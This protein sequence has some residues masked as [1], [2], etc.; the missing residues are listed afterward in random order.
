MTAGPL[1]PALAP[2]ARLMAL[3]YRAAIARV[4]RRYDRRVGVIELDRPVISVGNLSVG[5]TGK[6][7]AVMRLLAAL[8]DAGHR[9]CV[10]MRGYAPGASAGA[11]SDEAQEY[12]RAFPDLPIAARPDRIAALLELFATPQG[13]SVDCIVLDDGFQHRRLARVLDLVLVDAT[14]SPFR[15]RLLPAGWLREPVE[16]LA[17]ARAIVV[18][19]TES[20][21]GAATSELEAALRRA[22]PRALIVLARHEWAGLRVLG[23]DGVTRAE[24]VEWLRGRR[25]FAACAIGN[26]APFLAELDRRTGLS[27]AGELVLRDHDPYAPATIGRLLDAARA[28]GPGGAVVVTSKDWSKL[29]RVRPDAWPAEVVVPTLEMRWSDPTIEAT[30]VAAVRAYRP[31]AD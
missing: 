29:R 30:V 9:P 7:P 14:R 15:D 25:V 26:P 20:V 10:A 23:R 13:Q 1:P 2:L 22:A 6:T 21:A 5:G 12:R 3:V 17:R 19:H 18:T 31:A 16:S 28:V 8:R 4:N 11:D 24:P 27:R